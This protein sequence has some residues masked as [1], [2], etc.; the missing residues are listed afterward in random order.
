MRKNAN[1]KKR[2]RNHSH[3]SNE[4]SLSHEIVSTFNADEKHYWKQLNSSEKK[5]LATN[6]DNLQNSND[7]STTIPLSFKILNSKLDT[8][9]KKM[10]MAKIDQ[11]KMM[12]SHSGEYFKLR[13]W[14]NSVY[15]LPI[16]K[17]C[18]LPID[19]ITDKVKC[20]N[21]LDEVRDSFNRTVY[22]HN[23]AKE[24]ILCIIAQW[25]SNP[26]SRGHCIGI[27]GAMGVGKT[28]FI[29]DGLSKALGIPF[30]FVALGGASDASF[31]E[32]HGFTYEGSTYGK[33]AEV[34]MKTEC[35]NPIIFF[36]ELDKVS[37]THRGD[38]IIGVLTHLTDSSQNER[39]N[40]RYFGELDL[41]LSK[42]LII[43]SYN[44]ESK[45]NPVLKD[46]MI[47]INVK[48]YEAKDK[49]VI[50][51]NYLLPAIYKQYN[52]NPT[53][54]CFNENIIRNIIQRVQDEQGVRNLKRGLESIISWYNMNRYSISNSIVFPVEVNEDDVKKIIKLDD[55]GRNRFISTMYT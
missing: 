29:K 16:D 28:S 9:T 11:F 5:K 10:I 55:S 27:Q 41:D 2:H 31:L 8:I 22:G 4:D 26:S 54:I 37:N 7:V 6:Y 42:S 12:H 44:D 25:M 30:A 17:Y 51:S 1:S 23:E 18:K 33:I 47:T 39:F 45:I 43:F 32:G 20:T 46:R 19:D 50:A 14:L 52:F 36:D 3:N 35:M 34:L 38:E 48:G 53:D 21:F 13:T 15:R 49:V 24:Q 40:D